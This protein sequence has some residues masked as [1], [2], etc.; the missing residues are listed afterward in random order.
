MAT[1]ERGRAP[2]VLWILRV[3]V[4]LALAVDAIVHLR[5][6][7]GYQLGQPGGIGAGN[8]FRIESAAAILA[9]LYVLARG[10][11]P[12]FA[13]AFLVAFS[14]L[15]A[16]LV[17]RYVDVPQVGPIPSMYEPVWFF[18]KTL[19]AVAEAVGALAA[20]VGFA[21]ARPEGQGQGR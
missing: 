3:V 4:A 11:R 8:L 14:A 18:E 16:V 9:G 6:A 19:S 1:T 13:V 17:Y 12:A 20:A 2:L 10:T 5:L 7:S 15:V 21:L